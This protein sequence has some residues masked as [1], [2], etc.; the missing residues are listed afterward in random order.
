M[1]IKLKE[2]LSLIANTIRELSIDAVEKANSGHP[3]LPMGCAEIGAYL[4][5]VALNHNPSHFHWIARDR[6]VLSAGHGSMLLYSCL[7]LAGFKL[8]RKDI[9]NFRQL[10]SLTPGHPEFGTDGVEATT[11]PLGQ[12]LGN[13]VGLALG[14]KI[15]QAKFNKKEYPLFTNKIYCLLSDGCIMEGATSEAS[16]L[17]GLWKLDNLVAIYDCNH[18]CLDGPTSECLHED[19]KKRYK[20]YNWNVLEIDGNDL[21]QID[22]AISSLKEKQKKPTLIIAHTIIGKGS[23]NKAGTNKCHGSPLGKEEVVL[24]KEA[25]HLPQDPFTVPSRVYAFFEERRKMQQEK[26]QSWKALF[27]SWAEVYP[28]L[29]KEFLKMQDK[30]LPENFEEKLSQIAISSPVSGRKASGI[31]VNHLAKDLPFIYGGSADLSSSDMTFLEGMGIISSKNKKARNIK[32]GVREFAMATICS[33]LSLTGMMVPFCGTFLVFSDYM[34]NAIRLAAISPYHVIYQFTHDSFLLGEDGPTHQPIEQLASLRA[35]P[36]LLVIRPASNH[37]VKMAWIAA[38]HHIGP[39]AIVLSRQNMIDRP[40]T[41]K[42]YHEGLSK[43]AYIVK[44]EMT[45]PDYTIMATGS[46][47]SLAFEVSEALEK[48]GKSVRVISFPSFRLFDQQS[49]EYK[50][51]IL[52]GDIGKRISIE[53]ASS[54]G[55][56]KYIGREG[57]AISIDEFGSSA[58]MDQLKEKFGFTVD[59]ILRKIKE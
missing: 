3:G 46:E 37:E 36:N 43:G 13:S 26:E 29:H 39:T 22:Q 51:Q 54:F 17:A 44:Q 38:L 27:E 30:T 58:P 11:G 56:Q 41:N 55:W 25:L 52:G 35:M 24:T 14:Y 49:N 50:H 5:G 53:A 34:R 23:P 8:T 6:F 45:K 9:E 21:D 12:G 19:V 28:K 31:V 57:I 32:F 42:N 33:G 20:A 40:E 4:Y 18:I 16:S 10:D 2:D 48:K 59:A 15:L 47:L 7:H 1:D